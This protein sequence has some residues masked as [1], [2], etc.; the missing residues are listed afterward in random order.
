MA[1][2]A[3]PGDSHVFPV[4]ARPSSVPGQDDAVPTVVWKIS[5]FRPDRSTAMVCLLTSTLGVIFRC[6]PDN[7]AAHCSVTRNFRAQSGG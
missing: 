5:K 2:V 4:E 3:G 7:E 6:E 1:E